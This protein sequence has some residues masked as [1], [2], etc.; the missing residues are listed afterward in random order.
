MLRH[1]AG[2]P[3]LPLR[4]WSV[5]PYTDA[6]AVAIPGHFIALEGA[7]EV[8]MANCPECG[9]PWIELS[10]DADGDSA[11]RIVAAHD[12]AGVVEVAT[13]MRC[14]GVWWMTSDV[15]DDLTQLV[16]WRHGDERFQAPPPGPPTMV[17]RAVADGPIRAGQ[18]VGVVGWLPNARRVKPGD[19]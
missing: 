2:W 12:C 13:W 4:R 5:G 11:T 15:V 19:V 6:P 1:A 14:G 9:R 8:E 16:I 18:L 7:Q 17:V 10:R 3:L